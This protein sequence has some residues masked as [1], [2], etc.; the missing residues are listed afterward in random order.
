MVKNMKLFNASPAE[1]KGIVE[2]LTGLLLAEQSV[3]FAY[4]HG[5]FNEEGSFRDIDIAVYLDDNALQEEMLDQE[6]K[7]EGAIE[8]AFQYPVDVRVLNNAP[9][10]FSYMAIKKGIRMAIK[11][12]KK[13]VSFEMRTLKEYFDFL[14]FRRRYLRGA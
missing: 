5:S 11:D 1:K 13:R 3:L 4:L 8:S 2:K 10:H 14:P 12:D 7:L 9:A 6:L